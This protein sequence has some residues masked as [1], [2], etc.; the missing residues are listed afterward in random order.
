MNLKTSKSL[1]LLDLAFECFLHSKPFLFFP[2]DT[3]FDGRRV[4]S[5]LFGFL[6]SSSL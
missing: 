4:F 3:L 2:N 5:Q 6:I 1:K